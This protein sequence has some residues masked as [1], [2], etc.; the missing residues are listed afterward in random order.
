MVDVVDKMTRSRMMSG[1]RGKHTQP[2]VL[3]RRALHARGFRFRLH[4]NELP[5]R[6]DIVL[7]RFHAAI[8]VHG[9]FWHRHQHCVYCTRPASNIDFWN[10]KFSE[11]IARDQ[12]NLVSLKNLGWR[13]AIVW[14]CSLEAHAIEAVAGRLAKWLK[15]QSSFMEIPLRPKRRNARRPK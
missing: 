2:E 5:G 11:T 12:R 1:I 14:E 3:L 8:Q 4:A 7:P 15:G 10:R 13:T 9:C 6:P